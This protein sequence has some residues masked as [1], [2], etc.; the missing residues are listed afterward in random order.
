MVN[1]KTLT[2]TAN[3]DSKTY[4]SANPSPLGFSY[5]GGFVGTDTAA[6]IDTP[7]TCSSTATTTT[8]VGTAPITCSGG[9]DNNYAFSYIAG[10]LTI[11][12]KTL[13]VTANDDSKT[14]G[15]AN[16][17]PLGFSYSG[18]FVGTDTAAGIDTPP[19]CS[20]TATT[21]TPVGTAPITCS[22]GVDNNYSFTFVAGELTIT[23]A[24]LT[25][26][27]DDKSR[28][29]GDANPAFT[30][31]FTGFKNGET[32]A[33]SGV[34]G[35]PSCSTTA[36]AP[37]RSAPP[38]SRAPSARSPPAT[39]PS[40]SSPATL[41]IEKATLTVTADD[42]SRDYGDANPTFTATFTGFKNGETLATSGVTGSAELL[43]HGDGTT[44]VG[45]AAITCAVGTLAAGQL[46]LHLRRR[47]ADHRRR[48]R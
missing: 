47:D 37:R 14:Y 42:Q 20:S 4:G 13:T 6:G 29:Y 1:K 11:G 7:P 2:V 33:T 19:T 35:S 27:A 26:T 25:V 34:T 15:S 31:T 9:V 45:T 40:A 18:G 38:R 12:K 22:G 8:P 21:T 30:A 3:D 36:T 24:T 16:P 23:K 43:E 10:T 32:L 44:P 17:S 5:S 41:T 28:V 48:P 46:R 39:T